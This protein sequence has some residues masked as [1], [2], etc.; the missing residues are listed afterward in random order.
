MEVDSQLGLRASPGEMRR[1]TTQSQRCSVAI[2]EN[3]RFACGDVA[4][5]MSRVPSSAST[6][7][8]TLFPSGD[9][10]G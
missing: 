2:H 5:Q 6:A 3:G 9:Q 7:N 10:V 4:V 8:A 1:W